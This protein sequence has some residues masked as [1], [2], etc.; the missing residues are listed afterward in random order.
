MPGEG[1]GRML[2]SRARAE[3]AKIDYADTPCEQPHVLRL[4]PTRK[5][6]G[7]QAALMHSLPKG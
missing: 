2:A 1:K 5:S 6:T 7:E 4:A 3:W